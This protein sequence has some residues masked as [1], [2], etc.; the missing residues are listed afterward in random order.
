MSGEPRSVSVDDARSIIG[1][2]GLATIRS[3]W[4]YSWSLERFFDHLF[5]YEEADRLYVY[6][7]T[8]IHKWAPAPVFTNDDSLSTL[9]GWKGKECPYWFLKLSD[10]DSF[11]RRRS[12]VSSRPRTHFPSVQTYKPLKE[13]LGCHV[14][15]YSLFENMCMFIDIYDRLK[16]SRY[17]H[18]GEQCVK[19]ALQNNVKVPESWFVFYVL[20]GDVSEIPRGIALMIEDDRSCSALN[21]AAERATVSYGTYFLVEVIRCLCANGLS[22][23]DG[24]VS[25]NYGTY[26]RKIY[27]DVLPVDSSGRPPFLTS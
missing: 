1:S 16:D 21:I 3:A 6:H 18:S 10:F 8:P 12:D 9:T 19:E 5:V 13:R 26:K 22:S 7:P 4:H 27:L 2:C 20:V 11:L 25:G 17:R 14:R 23:F 15:R 24:G